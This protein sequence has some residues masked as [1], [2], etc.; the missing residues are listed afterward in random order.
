MWYYLTWLTMVLLS[1][2]QVA[3]TFCFLMQS[4]LLL[5]AFNKDRASLPLPNQNPSQL[6][7]L[8]VVNPPDRHTQEMINEK[9]KKAEDLGT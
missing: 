8:P 1:S 4:V 2:P 9:L 5:D 6:A 3:L 7:S